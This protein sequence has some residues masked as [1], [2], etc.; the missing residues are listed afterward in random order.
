LKGIDDNTKQL[1]GELRSA[2]TKQSMTMAVLAA[3]KPLQQIA[4]IEL[5][6]WAPEQDSDYAD[7]LTPD[8]IS[9]FSQDEIPEE[10]DSE[11]EQTWDHGPRPHTALA[12]TQTQDTGAKTNLDLDKLLQE[13]HGYRILFKQ[14]KQYTLPEYGKHDHKIPLKEGTSP[15]CKK[16]YQLSE[17]ETPI[18]KE[19]INKELSF[20]KI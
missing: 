5:L 2:V 19:Y 7:I 13:Y 6:G 3:I 16:L 8:D 9:E 14:P 17:K 11:P 12:A 4:M 1:R 20:R 15:A 10:T 18:L